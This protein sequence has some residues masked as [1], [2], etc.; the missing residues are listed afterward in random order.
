MCSPR[1]AMKFPFELDFFQRQAVLRLERKEHVFVAAHTS[2]GKTVVAEYAIALAKMHH[3]RTIYTSPIKALSNQKYRD[4]KN[5]FE[6]VGL[7][8]GD[9]S[10]QPEA[11]CLIMT[12]EILRSMLYR[13]S[14]VIRDVEW[15]IFDEVHYVNDS[16]R[17]VVWEEVLIMLPPSV[18][19]IMLSATTPNTMEFSDWIGRIKNRQVHVI[20]TTKRPVPL[21]HYLL[22]D[23]EVYHLQSSD[24]K[25]NPN[26]I[27]E[28]AKVQREKSK[29]KPKSSENAA[30]SNQRQMEKAAIAAQ[31]RGDNK[32]SKT[33]PGR[34]GGGKP[35]AT[36]SGGR[37]LG[38][39]AGG[40][41]QWLSL[42]HVLQNGGREAAG[43]VGA[44]H[45][46]GG[47]DVTARNQ[48]L[49]RERERWE[50]YENLPA[51]IRASM[52][53]KEY[54]K[55]QLTDIEPSSG[56]LPVVV[57]SFSKKKCEEIVDYMKGQDLLSGQEKHEVQAVIG[58]VR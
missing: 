25:Y 19:I 23:N 55:Q 31:N 48:E 33:A 57:F 45:F 27:A 22:H 36:G 34:G 53:K 9:V 49:R 58:M 12:T 1:L 4:F 43:G 7:I 16:E 41:S 8:T 54:E 56:L 35:S 26:V 20:S 42:L 13:G 24:G 28:A 39:A 40:K 46:V 32:I 11:A 30:A 47:V 18:N 15:V 6:D 3:T 50:K 44:I 21:Q 52:T 37:K 14:D 10:I 51:E 29:P 17:G 2:A 38:D 5:K